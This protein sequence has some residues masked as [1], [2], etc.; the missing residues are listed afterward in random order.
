[1]EYV[2]GGKY[3]W[4]EKDYKALLDFVDSLEDGKLYSLVASESY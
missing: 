3:Y 2:V 4:Q 1:M